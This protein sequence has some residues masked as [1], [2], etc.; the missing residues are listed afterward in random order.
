MQSSAP[1]RPPHRAHY[2]SHPLRLTSLPLPLPLPCTNM[3]AP[4]A[5][6]LDQLCA[7]P[8]ALK[9]AVVFGA[10]A[11]GLTCTRKGAIEGQPD[12]SEVEALA[13]TTTGWYNFW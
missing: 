7:D 11:G 3:Y 10:A 8:R 9:A 1:T 2:L 4:Q 5:G 13:E 12:L 6:G